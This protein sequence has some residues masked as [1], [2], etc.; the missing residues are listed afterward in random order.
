M[1][2]PGAADASSVFGRQALGFLGGVA[3][4]L[5]LRVMPLSPIGF[6]CWTLGY[7]VGRPYS[8]WSTP[9]RVTRD[10]EC[11]LPWCLRRGHASLPGDV[12]ELTK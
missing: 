7:L 11:S 9:G 2:Y 10:R 1:R 3:E 4:R 6:G 5:G 12:Y 8:L